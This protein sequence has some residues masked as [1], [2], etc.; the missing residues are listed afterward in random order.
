MHDSAHA[1]DILRQKL[2]DG[3]RAV[4]HPA[5]R[6][7]LL[8][9]SDQLAL[10][11]E[12]Y[13][14]HRHEKLLRQCIRIAEHAPTSL[15]AA[16]EN[17]E[18]AEAI[19]QWIHDTYDP[20][21]TPETN[22]GYRVALRVFGRRLTDGDD[23]PPSISWITT[24]LPR[25]YDPSPD[26]AAM[27]TEDDIESLLRAC[28][29]FR[30]RAAIAVQFDA[31]L[32]GS[33][34]YALTVDD[35]TEHEYGMLVR[36]DGKTGARSV[37]LIPSTPYLRLWL[38]DHP[39]GGDTPLWSKLHTAESLSYPGFLK[40]FQAPAGRAGLE[41]P[42][43][44]TNLRKSN[45]AWLVRQGMNA[46]SIEQRQGRVHG[47]DAVSRYVTLFDRDVGEEYAWLLGRIPDEEPINTRFGAQVCPRCDKDTPLSRSH[48]VWCGL[49]LGM[50]DED[51][52]N[53]VSLLE[54][55]A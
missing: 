33:E 47:S 35:V 45:L 29:S 3:D 46:R 37:L 8:Q 19:V 18:A 1:V 21:E 20:D 17:K 27:L 50:T 40:L 44:P 7:A 43:T 53:D 34:L 25:H 28:R 55:L 31:G 23:L 42:V 51:T 4:Q 10:H 16:L 11:R 15:V 32:R 24:S 52:G 26:P 12:T 49:D 41:K 54:A 30:D 9:F 6:D 48:C 13:G 39:G 22:Q 2:H 14:H 36:V 38:A 5:D